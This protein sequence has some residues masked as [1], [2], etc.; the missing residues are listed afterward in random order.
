MQLQQNY[1]IG[2]QSAT[3]NL[4]IT[5]PLTSSTS[6]LWKL[7]ASLATS[8]ARRTTAEIVPSTAFPGVDIVMYETVDDQQ[9]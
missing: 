4:H 8:T 1:F 3:S 6:L 9:S 5:D 2:F 7:T